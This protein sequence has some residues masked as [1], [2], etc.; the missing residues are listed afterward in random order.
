MLLIGYANN[1]GDGIVLYGDPSLG[2]AGLES[3]SISVDFS[4]QE[5][6]VQH[7]DGRILTVARGIDQIAFGYAEY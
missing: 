5:V 3:F 6:V 4:V 2:V 1:N 7:D